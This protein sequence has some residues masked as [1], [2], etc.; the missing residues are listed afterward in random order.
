MMM[1]LMMK[2]MMICQGRPST[3]NDDRNTGSDNDNDNDH[4]DRRLVIVIVIVTVSD[5][6]LVTMIYW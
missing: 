6:R 1:V 4:D 2:I 3:V 5:R